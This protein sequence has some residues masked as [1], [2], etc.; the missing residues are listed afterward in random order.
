[1]QI[2]SD[3]PFDDCHA[4]VDTDLNDFRP[5]IVLQEDHGPLH[6]KDK[7]PKNLPKAQKDM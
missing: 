3:L 4:L 2:E 6:L 7:I 5:R 1:M